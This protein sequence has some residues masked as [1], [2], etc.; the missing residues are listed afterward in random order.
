MCNKGNDIRLRSLQSTQA[1]YQKSH[2]I[3]IALSVWEQW[4]TAA[5]L[6]SL[7]PRCIILCVC[8]FFLIFCL[9]VFL[10]LYGFQS[11]FLSLTPW[12]HHT[13]LISFGVIYYFPWTLSQTYIIKLYILPS[14]K[15]AMIDK[16]K[17]P[18]YEWE[19][20]KH[21]DVISL[22]QF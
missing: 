3:T 13:R 1:L 10:L 16:N 4:C 2:P 19:E 15:Y 20:R 12:L 11:L 9:I 22:H 14:N 7:F 17:P 18:I 6:T 5:H 21:T 8:V